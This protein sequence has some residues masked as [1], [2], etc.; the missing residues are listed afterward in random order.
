MCTVGHLQQIIG[1]K[2]STLFNLLLLNTHILDHKGGRG[3]GFIKNVRS[4]RYI[5]GITDA[6][7]CHCCPPVPRILVP[8][9][10]IKYLQSASRVCV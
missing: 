4:F 1:N 9:L 5:D 10:N 6:Y 8:T 7:L 2:F 3:Q